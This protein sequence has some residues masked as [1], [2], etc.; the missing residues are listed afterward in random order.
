MKIQNKIWTYENITRNN[1][2]NKDPA[3]RQFQRTDHHKQTSGHK[4]MADDR[5]MSSFNETKRDKTEKFAHF[6]SLS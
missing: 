4:W 5:V 6:Q 3:N 2:C 1:K